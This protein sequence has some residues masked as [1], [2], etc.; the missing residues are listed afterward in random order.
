MFLYLAFLIYPILLL[1]SSEELQLSTHQFTNLPIELLFIIKSDAGTAFLRTHEKAYQLL[2]KLNTKKVKKIVDDIARKNLFEKN[3][4]RDVFN[5]GYNKGHKDTPDGL[6]SAWNKQYNKLVTDPTF[7]LKFFRCDKE[8]FESGMIF[9]NY[10]TLKILRKEVPIIITIDNDNSLV[11]ELVRL[12]IFTP[13]IEKNDNAKLILVD[14]DFVAKKSIK[15]LEI[16]YNKAKICIEKIVKSYVPF[17]RLVFKDNFLYSVVGDVLKNNSYDSECSKYIIQDVSA[18]TVF[19]RTNYFGHINLRTTSLPY[20]LENYKTFNNDIL[21]V[22]TKKNYTLLFF[23]PKKC[24]ELFADICI[25]ERDR[26]GNSA[27]LFQ[28]KHYNNR[29]GVWY[30][31]DD[32][33]FEWF[34]GNVKALINNGIH[35]NFLGKNNNNALHLVAELNYPDVLEMLSEGKFFHE[36]LRQKNLDNYTPL[37]QALKS[38]KAYKTETSKEKNLKVIEFLLY[39]GAVT[40]QHV[41]HNRDIFQACLLTTN[42]LPF[43]VNIFL[44]KINAKFSAKDILEHIVKIPFYKN[45]LNKQYKNG[46]TPLDL[47]YNANNAAAIGVLEENGALRS[48]KNQ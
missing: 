2:K 6:G 7:F 18:N 36:A 38:R 4:D 25:N 42:N 9:P 28:I 5:K 47:A 40:A 31:V 15:K 37:D 48:Q 23:Y 34:Q 20:N 17:A 39:H 22:K 10:I 11:N 30:L 1:A 41:K 19:D 27:L 32:N 45:R 14:D 44:E 33:H 26:D 13:L 21:K 16:Q 8:F 3:Y 24:I 12:V 29:R 46:D 43:T 35:I